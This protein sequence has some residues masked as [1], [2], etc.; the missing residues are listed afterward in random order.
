MGNVMQE[1]ETKVEIKII[2]QREL[3]TDR[4]PD[5]IGQAPFWTLLQLGYL[6]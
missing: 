2:N 6:K 4:H 5:S 3:I 1:N